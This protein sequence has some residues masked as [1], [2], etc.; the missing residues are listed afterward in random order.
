MFPFT[1]LSDA[2]FAFNGATD[3][4]VVTVAFGRALIFVL[5]I[6][7]PCL[8]IVSGGW[9]IFYRKSGT[10]AGYKSTC[11]LYKVLAVVLSFLL[12][13]DFIYLNE[14]Y[15]RSNMFLSLLM[16]AVVF[17]PTLAAYVIAVRGCS[18][19]MSLRNMAEPFDKTIWLG[20]VS[21][22]DDGSDTYK[23]AIYAFSRALAVFF[24]RLICFMVLFFLFA[25]LYR[26]GYEA[27]A[28]LKDLSNIYTVCCALS[29]NSSSSYTGFRYAYGRV[30]IPSFQSDTSKWVCC[31]RTYYSSASETGWDWEEPRLI[32]RGSS[33]LIPTP[34]EKG[35]GVS[36]SSTGDVVIDSWDKVDEEEEARRLM[37]DW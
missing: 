12:V 6:V 28:E 13:L 31:G 34:G 21:V 16:F 10:A 22:S 1:S 35:W 18:L 37:R 32:W 9:A 14:L 19:A 33:V 30:I 20:I 3:A 7:S 8:L 17:S 25:G 24:G 11:V 4:K 27:S 29:G 36:L 2:P 26:Q 23:D 15:L 5:S